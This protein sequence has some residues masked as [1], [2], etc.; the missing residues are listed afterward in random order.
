LGGRPHRS[1]R[2]NGH[3]WVFKFFRYGGQL[4]GEWNFGNKRNVSDVGKCGNG[5]KLGNV[6]FVRKLRD[7]CSVRKLRV[8]RGIRK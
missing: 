4:R 1:P 6:G 8:S 2:H 7:K 3:E 5:R